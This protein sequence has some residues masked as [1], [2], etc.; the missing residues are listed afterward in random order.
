MLNWISKLMVNRYGVDRLSFF[1]LLMA[2]ILSLIVGMLGFDILSVLPL[3]L[4]VWA[5][6]R[7]FSK[8]IS[9][10]SK[11]NRIYLAYESKFTSKFSSL[12]AT[13]AESKTYHHFKCPECSQK[14]RIP[15]GRGKIAI[16]CPKCQKEFTKKS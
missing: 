1:I 4:M 10:R 11:E 7:I 13:L 6:Y 5:V 2:S 16:T 14:I 8:K 15:K 3:L 12:P 9:N